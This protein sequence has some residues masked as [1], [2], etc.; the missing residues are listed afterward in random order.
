MKE[1]TEEQISKA[2]KELQEQG[3]EPKW[4]AFDNELITMLDYLMITDE[5]TNRVVDPIVSATIMYAW[6]RYFKDGVLPDKVIEP[7][8]NASHP[9]VKHMLKNV[10][11][12]GC[13][14]IDI[15]YVEYWN[16]KNNGRKGGLAKA[17]NNQT[18]DTF[19]DI[20]WNDNP[21]NA[22]SGDILPPQ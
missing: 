20:D 5:K 10:L 19:L 4:F 8:V 7:C 11:Y 1:Y 22:I 9:A 15:A 14:L 21:E 17:R 16:A 13:K 6:I 3:I 12:H 2:R 18:D